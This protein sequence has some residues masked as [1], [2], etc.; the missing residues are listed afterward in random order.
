MGMAICLAVGAS[1]FPL[2][3][4]LQ[5]GAALRRGEN[6]KA[7]V[8]GPGDSIAPRRT[9]RTWMIAAVLAVVLTGGLLGF[10]LLTS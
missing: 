7:A 3:A 10:V 5:I 8:F 9:L 1:V 6:P 4:G 2:G